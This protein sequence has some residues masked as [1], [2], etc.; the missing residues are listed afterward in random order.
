ME[1]ENCRLE[2]QVFRVG[3]PISDSCAASVD[4]KSENDFP[5]T[6]LEALDI[7]KCSVVLQCIEVLCS[8]VLDS[9]AHCNIGSSQHMTC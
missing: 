9:A 6:G 8:A 1:I 3:S 2:I 4:I 7:A 5:I